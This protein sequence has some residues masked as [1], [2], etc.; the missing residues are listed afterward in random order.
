MGRKNDAILYAGVI[1]YTVSYEDEKQ[2][3]QIVKQ[4]PSS[5]AEMIQ[6]A[7]KLTQKSPQFLEI[8]KEAGFDFYKIAPNIFAPA[9]VSV[10]NIK[11]GRTF[12][13]GDMDIK[14]INGSL[15]L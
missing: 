12:R 5:A 11:T 6:E 7:L 9:I 4:A 15:G 1:H 13:A 8:F 14:A 2:L 3:E 10:N